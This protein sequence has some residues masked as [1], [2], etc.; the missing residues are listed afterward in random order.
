MGDG[1]QL[2]TTALD[3]LLR[4]LRQ[5]LPVVRVGILGSTASRT[6]GEKSNG[7]NNAEV[8]AAHEFGTSKMPQRSFLRVPLNDNLNTAVSLAGGYDDDTL[9]E[10]IKLGS[11][12]PWLEKIAKVAEGVVLDA[13]NTAGF[14]KWKPWSTGY[15]NTTGT[16]L[17]DTTQLRDSITSDVK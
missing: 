15:S 3:G 8:G 2:N 17:V 11:I 7:P 14:G 6:S 4:A 10:V 13:F 9:K 1:V 5:K 16:L 12:K